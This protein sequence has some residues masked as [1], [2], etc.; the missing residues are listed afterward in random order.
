MVPWELTIRKV[1]NGFRLTW[2]EETDGGTGIEVVERESVL[3]GG[4]DDAGVMMRLGYEV[5]EYFG[6][7]PSKHD[8]KRAVISIKGDENA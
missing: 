3:E 1:D 7:M 5:W 8:A 4:E 2:R 6:Y